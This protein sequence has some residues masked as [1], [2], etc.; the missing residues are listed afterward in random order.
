MRRDAR[1]SRMIA[2]RIDDDCTREYTYVR[3]LYIYDKRV[4]V[5]SLTGVAPRSDAQP[6]LPLCSSLGSAA[7]AFLPSSDNHSREHAIDRAHRTRTEQYLSRSYKKKENISRG[8]LPI[9]PDPAPRTRRVSNI[10]GDSLSSRRR[11]ERSIHHN[12]L[13]WSRSAIDRDRLGFRVEL[14]RAIKSHVS[15]YSVYSRLTETEL[16]KTPIVVRADPPF[17]A[18]RS[19][20][21]A[22]PSFLNSYAL[23]P[24]GTGNAVK[25]YH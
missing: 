13:R 20:G 5:N 8:A 3:T 22:A 10:L 25:R 19:L 6:Q 17:V 24:R 18:K 1:Q 23:R 21:E 16:S 14:E 15:R 12:G 9:T 7:I 4:C 11:V 2:P